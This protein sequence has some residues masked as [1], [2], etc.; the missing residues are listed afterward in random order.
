MPNTSDRVERFDQI[1]STYTAALD[2]QRLPKFIQA[3]IQHKPVS[4][5]G[6]VYTIQHIHLT[7]VKTIVV[8]K[9]VKE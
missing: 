7:P 5:Q 9:E 6:E 8:L 1:Y 2:D 3:M 4:F